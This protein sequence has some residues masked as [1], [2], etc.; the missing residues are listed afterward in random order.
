M[1]TINNFTKETSCNGKKRE[2]AE[3]P[4]IFELNSMGRKSIT[5]DEIH[6]L[7]GLRKKNSILLIFR[8]LF[9]G[10]LVLIALS[11]ILKVMMIMSISTEPLLP[12]FLVWIIN[13]I[14]Y[15]GM[16]FFMAGIV[17]V[18]LPLGGRKIWLNP[19]E[20][21]VFDILTKKSVK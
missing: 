20:R 4:D 14:F 19:E 11:A 17:V 8:Y 9:I 12:L 3:L 1:K 21:R 5:L 2:T 10:G 16:V 13:G 15:M 6:D 7:I 18:I